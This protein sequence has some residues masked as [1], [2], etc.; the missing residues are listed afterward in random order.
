MSIKHILTGKCSK[1]KNLT[2]IEPQGHD[3]KNPGKGP[4]DRVPHTQ[5]QVLQLLV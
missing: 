2:Q 3:L 5:L 4:L 1:I